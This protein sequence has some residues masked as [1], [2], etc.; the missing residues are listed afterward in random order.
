M[1]I[2]DTQSPQSDDPD[3]DSPSAIDD[4]D[5]NTDEGLVCP[6]C[7]YN[8]TG[9]SGNQC[10]ECGAIIDWA[11]VCAARQKDEDG[12]GTDWDRFRG[13][14][15]P[16]GFFVTAFRATT[17]PWILARQLRIS[18]DPN[19]PLGFLLICMIGAITIG[20][21]LHDVDTNLCISWII[22]VATCV[23][24][25]TIVFGLWLPV[26]RQR[27]S[28]RYWFAVSAYTSYPL[29]LEGFVGEPPY[30]ILGTSNIWP[31]FSWRGPHNAVITVIYYVW[32]IGLVVIAGT[33]LSRRRHRRVYLLIAAIPVLT[34]IS[35][36]SGCYFSDLIF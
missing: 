25:Q 33:R 18:P 16:L 24:L 35:S 2:S 12:P 17:T 26:G 4:P 29:L 21:S 30:I 36:Y 6:S 10:P 9:L 20:R 14:R 8:L 3:I 5:F 23:L 7:E 22:G 11:Q 13:L 31:L 32:L 15:R 19:A 1:S 27:S 34:C 28:H